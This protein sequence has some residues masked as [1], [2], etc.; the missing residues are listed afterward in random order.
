MV[1]I[2]NKLITPPHWNDMPLSLLLKCYLVMGIPALVTPESEMMWR[3]L[4]VASMIAGWNQAWLDKWRADVIRVHGPDEGDDIYLDE[5]QQVVMDI[6]RHLWAKVET[7]DDEDDD[8]PAIQKDED[9]EAQWALALTLTRCPYPSVVIEGKT[10]H[11]PADE[12]GNVTFYE[13]GMLWEYLK[14]FMTTGDD[15]LMHTALAI[16]YREAKADTQE[17]I[18]SKYSG[19]IRLPLQHYEATIPDRATAWEQVQRPIKNV[20]MYWAICCRQQYYNAY[21]DIFDTGGAPTGGS[22][23][24]DQLIMELAPS[25]TQVAEVAAQPAHNVFMWLRKEKE[26]AARRRKA[27]G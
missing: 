2:N 10:Y 16:M 26:D 23:G 13:L 27:E 5:V 24:F 21:L 1:E 14:A 3:R 15:K 12:W 9:E 8:E 20:L 22:S 7:D 19:D 11:A 6:T 18:A 4:I 25:V 17:N